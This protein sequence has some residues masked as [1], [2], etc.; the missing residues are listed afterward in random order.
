MKPRRRWRREWCRFSHERREYPGRLLRQH[1]RSTSRAIPPIHRRVSRSKMKTKLCDI[2]PQASQ[3]LPHL[4]D[5]KS[6]VGAHYVDAWLKPMNAQAARRHAVKCKRRGLKITLTIGAKKGEGLLRQVGGQHRSD[7][8]A[9][10]SPTGSRQGGGRGAERRGWGDFSCRVKESYFTPT[11]I[12]S[13]P[14]KYSTR[15]S[16]KPASFS[17]PWQSAPV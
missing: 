14:T 1:A 7:R 2:N 13:G 16:R 15:V 9:R 17:Q 11:T 3:K 5:D 8:H 4:T 10:C 6:G 12:E